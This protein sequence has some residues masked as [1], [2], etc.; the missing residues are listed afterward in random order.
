MSTIIGYEKTS[1]NTLK[2]IHANL[3]NSPKLRHQ[4]IN[5]KLWIY[6]IGDLYNCKKECEK[7][8]EKKYDCLH[9]FNFFGKKFYANV[10]KKDYQKIISSLN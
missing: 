4:Y 3:E 8:R 10:F 9:E 2:A 6:T 5:G 7:N 1:K